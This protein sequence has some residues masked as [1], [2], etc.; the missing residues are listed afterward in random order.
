MERDGNGTKI[1]IR[2]YVINSWAS[3]KYIVISQ[4]TADRPNLS[5]RAD[6]HDTSL[7]TAAYSMRPCKHAGRVGVHNT[8]SISDPAVLLHRAHHLHI[9]LGLFKGTW[10]LP[11]AWIW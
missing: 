4:P 6:R 3:A 2:N 8:S 1:L 7:V 10:H 5:C 9:A 11:C